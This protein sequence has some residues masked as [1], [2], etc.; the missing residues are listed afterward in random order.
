MGEVERVNSTFA[1]GLQGSQHH[2]VDQAPQRHPRKHQEK[3][4]QDD[5]VELHS[6][7]ETQTD[8]MPKVIRLDSDDLD[9]SA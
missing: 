4:Q 7:E 1:T 9:L 5:T 3:H 2:R 6:E 8:E